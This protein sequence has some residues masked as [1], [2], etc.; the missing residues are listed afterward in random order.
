MARRILGSVMPRRSI[1]SLTMRRRSPTQG[2]NG[3]GGISK[4]R[5]LAEILPQRSDTSVEAPRA[6]E[7]ATIHAAVRRQ[8]G[9][10]PFA[11]GSFMRDTRRQWRCH[12]DR[13]HPAMPF[14]V[15]IV[16][17]LFLCGVAACGHAGER[18]AQD[19]LHAIDQGKVVGTRGTMENLGKA[20]T[21][22]SMD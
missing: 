11:G 3:S 20:L 10:S 12:P 22:Y 9:P 8:P 7:F 2:S 1:C 18:A 14:S 19:V 16:T 5:C 6:L 15:S 17:L 13:I 21:S 4:G